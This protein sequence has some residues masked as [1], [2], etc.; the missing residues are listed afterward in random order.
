MKRLAILLTLAAT[1]AL[2]QTLEQRIGAQIGACS[3]QNTALAMQVEQLQARV[4]ELEAAAKSAE[5]T[6]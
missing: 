1:P 4:K 6:K 2:A 3:L 5:P